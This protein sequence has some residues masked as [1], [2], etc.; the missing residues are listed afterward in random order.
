MDYIVYIYRPAQ[1]GFFLL[2]WVVK[3]EKTEKF[4]Y[5]EKI[6]RETD[7]EKQQSIVK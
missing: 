5:Q 4:Q 3:V 6:K 1:V 2:H 7:G